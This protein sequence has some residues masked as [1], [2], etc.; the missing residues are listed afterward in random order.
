[1]GVTRRKAVPSRPSDSMAR[2]ATSSAGRPCPQ[3]GSGSR[4]GARTRWTR[5]GRRSRSAR[6]SGS[7][8][9]RTGRQ[10]AGRVVDAVAQG[11]AAPVRQVGG[12]RIVGAGH[13]QHVLVQP[14]HHR[15]P[16]AGHRLE[17]A[18][19]VELVA[20][21]VAKGDGVRPQ[22]LR[23]A[24][25]GGLVGLEQAQEAPVVAG[26]QGRG[27]AGQ[28][29]GARRV[30]AQGDL[31]AQDLG[32][33]SARRGLAVGGRDQHRAQREP[34]G[35]L[36]RGCRGRE[37]RARGPG[38]WCRH[39]V[40]RRGKGP[41][42]AAPRAA[43]QGAGGRPHAPAVAYSATR[44]TRSRRRTMTTGSPPRRTSIAAARG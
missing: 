25:Q 13:E 37:P 3:C 26:G 28:Q 1:M 44:A 42:R 9:N 35:Q 8:R 10:R 5:S 36:G 12:D 17:L 4:P 20:E 31:A 15:P 18:V 6:T 2:A 33:H 40:Q 39:P 32:R 38:G 41:R 14:L 23:Q 29:V 7:R 16:A 24:R 11:G 27:H 34:A 30:A 43:R 22:A 19:A 21:E